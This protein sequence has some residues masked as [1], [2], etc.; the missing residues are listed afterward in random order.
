MQIF[1]GDLDDPGREAA[2]MIEISVV[3]AALK[4][5]SREFGVERERRYVLQLAT[6]LI[7]LSND[8]IV[9]T[10]E[11]ITTA[12]REF[13]IGFNQANSIQTEEG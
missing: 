5:L 11:L 10:E 3:N 13:A 1:A 12:R 9:D 7:R 4:M 2:A 6:L 8:G